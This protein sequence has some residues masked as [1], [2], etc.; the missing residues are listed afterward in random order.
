VRH[1]AGRIPERTGYRQAG[2]AGGKGARELEAR[3]L[4]ILDKSFEREYEDPKSA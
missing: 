4:S 3:M 2:Q 1:G